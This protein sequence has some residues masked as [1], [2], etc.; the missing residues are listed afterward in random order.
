MCLKLIL[1]VYITLHTTGCHVKIVL[2]YLIVECRTW[3]S[4]VICTCLLLEDNECTMEARHMTFTVKLDYRRTHTRCMKCYLLVKNNNHG[5]AAKRLKLSHKFGAL[6]T[7]HLL[8]SACRL[9][10]FKEKKRHKLI[11]QRFV[12]VTVDT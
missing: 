4:G 8:V 7:L 6:C 10:H 3:R 11:P 2:R 5:D 9:K 12:E 1:L